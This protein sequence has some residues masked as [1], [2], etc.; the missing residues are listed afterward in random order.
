MAAASPW[1]VLRREL[2]VREPNEA[3]GCGGEVQLLWGG[4]AATRTQVG[5]CVELAAG[6]A[7]YA[8]TFC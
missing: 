5:A 3:E 8:H 6:L 2:V 4:A 7:V 1:G